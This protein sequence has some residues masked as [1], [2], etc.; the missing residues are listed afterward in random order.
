VV[1]LYISKTF[2]KYQH[3]IKHVFVFYII[4]KKGGTLASVV[5]IL[6]G[7]TTKQLKEASAPD[8]LVPPESSYRPKEKDLRFVRYDKVLF[9]SVV[10]VVVVVVVAKK[11]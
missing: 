1:H 9:I 7:T 6:T 2:L 5:G 4:T 11:N 3:F 10:V 8:S